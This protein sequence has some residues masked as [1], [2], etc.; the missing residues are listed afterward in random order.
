MVDLHRLRGDLAEAATQPTG[1]RARR[2]CELC[3]VAVPVAGADSLMADANR[4]DILYSSDAYATELEELQFGLG[5]GP[6]VAA[7]ASG[8]RCWS[9]I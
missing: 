8:R 3:V 7:F 2:I 4:R 9:P 5:E 1:Q 6:C